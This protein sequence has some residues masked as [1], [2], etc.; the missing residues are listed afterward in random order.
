MRVT[1]FRILIIGT[2]RIDVKEDLSIALVKDFGIHL[3]HEVH[4]VVT[5]VTGGVA[6]Q[7]AFFFQPRVELGPRRSLQ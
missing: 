3:G 2:R 5:V 7:T 6:Q 1:F 4:G